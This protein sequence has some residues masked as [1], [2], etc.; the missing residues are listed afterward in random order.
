V[1]YKRTKVAA[2]LLVLD[3][4]AAGFDA[5]V[6]NPTTPVGPGDRKPTPTGR[7]IAG[8]ACGRIRG[9]LATTGLNVVDVADVAS[10]HV[11]ALERG[12]PSRRYL[13]GGSN[14]W[15]Q[16][17]FAQI[18]A[19]A[20]R[21]S[22]RIRVPYPAA[23][24]AAALGLANRHEVRLARLPMFFS[25]ARAKLELG[26]EPG[27]V[28]SALACAVREALKQPAEAATEIATPRPQRGD[29]PLFGIKAQ[30]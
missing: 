7:M 1:P 24:A 12:R 15:L 2:E 17:L 9:Y 29:A 16:E 6:V 23:V 10:G 14:L 19:A 30:P 21:T 11:L 4:A 27:P 28:D 5:V 26:Y 13:L 25:S 18:A 8:V 3:A 22:P 20:G